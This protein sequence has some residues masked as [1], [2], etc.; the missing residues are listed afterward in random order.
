MPRLTEGVYKAKSGS[1]RKK[2]VASTRVCAMADQLARESKRKCNVA[3]RAIL[4]LRR[5]RA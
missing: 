5:K 4:E 3:R 2:L 1:K